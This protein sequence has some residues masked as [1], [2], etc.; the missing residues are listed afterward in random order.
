MRMPGHPR[1]FFDL[2]RM[3]SNLL[4]TFWNLS[5]L[6]EGERLQAAKE[7]ITL[8]EEHQVPTIPA[9]LQIVIFLVVFQGCDEEVV[10]SELEYAVQRLVKG[11]S[12]NRKGARSGFYTALTQVCKTVRL[13]TSCEI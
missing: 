7:L 1:G 9:S 2:L 4:Q 5:S 8:L 12:S 6:E 13:L 11:L 10:C 3:E